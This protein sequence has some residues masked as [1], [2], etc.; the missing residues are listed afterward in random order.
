MRLT[1]S[2]LK[3]QLAQGTDIL[4]GLFNTGQRAAESVL[5]SSLSKIIP[6]SQSYCPAATQ[7]EYPERFPWLMISVAPGYQLKVG[8]PGRHSAQASDE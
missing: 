7:S 5:S 2:G 3:L 4:P 8:K 6:D 1:G